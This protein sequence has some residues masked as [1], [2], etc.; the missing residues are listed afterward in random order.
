MNRFSHWKINNKKLTCFP[1]SWK[2]SQ[3]PLKTTSLKQILLSFKK[4]VTWLESFKYCTFWTVELSMKRRRMRSLH[5]SRIMLNA[6]CQRLRLNTANFSFSYAFWFD[7]ALAEVCFYVLLP[8]K[9]FFCCMTHFSC[10][11]WLI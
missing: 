5:H 9:Q 7:D 4:S 8:A 6:T 10:A 11:I 1:C 3:K 2:T